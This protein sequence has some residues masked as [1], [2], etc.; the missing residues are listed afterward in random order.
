MI[1]KN[2]LN[3][4]I[5]HSRFK[6]IFQGDDLKKLKNNLFS[7][8]P[9]L[10]LN[11]YNFFNTFIKKELS[12]SILNCICSSNNFKQVGVSD[13]CGVEYS[14]VICTD[15]GLIRAEKYFRPEILAEFYSK[16]YRN[17]N[18]IHNDYDKFYNQQSI[19]GKKKFNIISD[20]IKKDHKTVCDIG[21]GVGG[22]MEAFPKNFKKILVDFY[23]PYLDY[24]KSKQIE[25]VRGD[26]ES[27]E[28]KPDIII[29][30]HVVEHIPDL[31][32]FLEKLANVQK[33]NITLNYIEFPGIDSL[34]NG[35]RGADLLGDIHIPHCYY[36]SSYIFENIMN[37]FGFKSIY[38]DEESRGIFIYTGKKKNKKNFYF[39]IEKDLILAEKRR[40]YEILRRVA[41]N[42]IPFLKYLRNLIKKFYQ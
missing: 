33:T 27:L 34:K 29:L 13:R 10:D 4:I 2:K 15:C 26:I 17:L 37:Q 35:R 18:K 22:V 5:D 8:F 36:F 19:A 6:R 1:F 30:N 7:E 12:K 42:H 16:Y 39:Q 25:T 28:C 9:F 41:L 11:Y 21:G 31:S 24:A 23:I 20:F 32:R 14:V 3:Y 40:K 38:L